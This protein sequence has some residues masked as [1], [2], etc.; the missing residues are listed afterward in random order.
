MP[1]KSAEAVLTALRSQNGVDSLLRIQSDA[2]SVFIPLT[3]S[4]RSYGRYAILRRDPVLTTKSDKPQVMHGSY[5]RIGDIAIVKIRNMGRAM[6]LADALIGSH[7]GIRAVYRDTGLES[8]FRTRKLQYL[9]GEKIT[10]TYHQE[11]GVRF[12]LDVSRV[13]FSPRLATERSRILTAVRDGERIIDMFAGIGPFSITIA[14]SKEAMID[15]VDSNPY[16]I[17]Y[18]KEST[19]LNKL[20]GKITPWL[21][22]AEDVTPGLGI[23]DRVIM[24]LPFGGTRYLP[25]AHSVLRPGGL[26][27]FYTI[28]D[29]MEIEQG[30]ESARTNGFSLE[31]KRIVHGYSPGRDMVLLLLKKHAKIDSLDTAFER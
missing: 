31:D 17:Q 2:D 13:Y 22:R 5:D 27:H 20:R 10:E 14:K 3:D 9:V 16:A 26:A 12:H 1:R 21:G 29:V 23:A 18:M 11:N 19:A 25:L 28:G 7:T 24:N 6:Q 4:L 30:M 8:E 15:A